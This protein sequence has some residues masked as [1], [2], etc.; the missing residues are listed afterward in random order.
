[1]RSLSFKQFALLAATAAVGTTT[2]SRSTTTFAFV[3]SSMVA[4]RTRSARSNNHAIANN[5]LRKSSSFRLQSTVEKRPEAE[6]EITEEQA[7][8]KSLPK[9]IQGGMGIRISSWQ[10]AREVARKGGLGVISGT[11]MDVVFVRTLQDGDPGGHFRRALATFPNQAMVQRALLKYYLPEGKSPHKPYRS[12]PMW[13]FQPPRQLE[14]AAILGN[15]CEV[16]LAKHDDDGTPIEGNGKVGINRLTKVAMPTIHSLYGSM[17]AG[18]D[19]VIM[20]AGIPTKIPGI[21]DALAEGRDCSLSIEVAGA[22]DEDADK[23]AMNF[24]PQAFWAET[25]TPDIAREPLQRPDFLPIVSSTTLAQSLIKRANGAGPTRGINGFVIELNTAGGHNAPPRGWK[26]EPNSEEPKY[27]EKDMVEVQKFAKVA[28]G[29][30][31]WFAG[32]YGRKEKLSEVLEGGGN[33][34]QVGTLFALSDESGMDPSIK[35]QI[36]SE[37]ASGKHLQVYTDPAASPTGFPF[38]VLQIDVGNTLAVPEIYDT[39]PRVC[40]L[41]YLRVPYLEE[42]GKLAYKCPSEPVEDYVAK[43][44]DFEATIGRK[45]LCNALCADAGFPQVRHIKDEETGEKK[46]FVE[47]GL[48]TVGDD[49]NQ[50]ASLLKQR[51]DGTWGFSAAD[52]VDYLLADLEEKEEVGSVQEQLKELRP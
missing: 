22:S 23:Y 13:S 49:V 45:C 39:R 8:K 19:Y 48:V 43:G 12:L 32:S 41:G 1:M 30:P 14:E 35:Q 27:G 17:L 36:L 11:A 33:G 38:K 9:I 47:P 3:P 4:T 20:G 6:A 5:I 46:E 42:D 44:G 18:V 2:T 24:S 40:N 51:E 52:V 31:Y 16:W 50:C 26:Y 37:I 15:Y 29:L 21:L 7:G 25:D 28:K 34:V 10:L